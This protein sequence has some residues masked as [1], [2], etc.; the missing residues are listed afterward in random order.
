MK[1]VTAL[2]RAAVALVLALAAV[3]P[4]AAQTNLVSDASFE[5]IRWQKCGAGVTYVQR[6]AAQSR[7]VY[8]GNVAL[9]IDRSAAAGAECEKAL[10]WNTYAFVKMAVQVPQDAETLTLSFRLSRVGNPG[11]S[12]SV[13]V[14][15]YDDFYGYS[16]PY[17]STTVRPNLVAGWHLVT[18]TLPRSKVVEMRG[19]TAY[20]FFY[21]DEGDDIYG[22]GY[23]IPDEP[24]QGWYVDD[25]RLVSGDPYAETAAPPTLPRPDKL[26][27]FD[28]NSNVVVANADGTAPRVVWANDEAGA[29]PTFAMWTPSGT[30]LI[31]VKS[32]VN[33]AILPPASY[34]TPCG[35]FDVLIANADGSDRRLL[36]TQTCSPGNWENAASYAEIP[37]MSWEWQWLVMTRDERKLALDYRANFF[38]RYPILSNLSTGPAGHRLV[39]IDVATAQSRGNVGRGIPS[40][41]DYRR[42]GTLVYSL[43]GNDYVPEQKPGVFALPNAAGAPVRLTNPPFATIG[44]YNLVSDRSL[45]ITPDDRYMVSARRAPGYFYEYPADGSE[46]GVGEIW[47][48]ARTDL[49]TGYSD[50]ISTLRTGQPYNFMLS[51]D[52]QYLFFQTTGRDPYGAPARGDESA[53]ASDRSAASVAPAAPSPGRM[54]GAWADAARPGKA[55]GAEPAARWLRLADGAHGL[56]PAWPGGLTSVDGRY[57]PPGGCVAPTASDDDAPLLA[58]SDA[59]LAVGPNPVRGSARVAFRTAQAGLARLAVYDALGR[60]VAVLVDEVRAA[61]PHAA[62][63]DASGAAPGVYLLRLT[64]DGVPLATAR[65]LVVR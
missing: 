41:M 64:L 28:D 57:C 51:P 33:P 55:A 30:R 3:R 61:G 20:V 27:Y 22:G 40:G 36:W 13:A 19:K 59:A 43:T 42:D 49:A 24:E 39:E 8:D 25:V 31:V 17:R 6:E 60:E 58:G 35:Y 9:R 11:A 48:I 7:K 37:A 10:V 63:W 50:V 65:V 4:A 54:R 53:P 47:E 52:G 12:L 2:R 45:A 38:L 21:Q 15:P 5:N 23:Q 62:A 32:R 18:L 1:T 34:L 46:Q 44:D 26:L 16:I 56:M 29:P 14:S